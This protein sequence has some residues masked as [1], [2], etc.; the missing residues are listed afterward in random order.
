MEDLVSFSLRIPKT[1]AASIEAAAKH[2]GVSKSEYTRRAM[3]ELEARLMRERIAKLSRQLAAHSAAAARSMEDS[4]ADGF[5]RPRI[6]S[7]TRIC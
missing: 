3:E 5:K 6:C 2:L 4:T 1:L 7:T